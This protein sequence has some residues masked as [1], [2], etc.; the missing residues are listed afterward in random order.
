MPKMSPQETLIKIITK[1]S[2]FRGR[3]AVSEPGLTELPIN[4]VINMKKRRME[5]QFTSFDKY[6]RDIEN[7]PDTEL[8]DQNSVPVRCK[9]SC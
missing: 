7:S 6:G 1:L 4:H 8:P 3:K 2:T 9:S 5:F